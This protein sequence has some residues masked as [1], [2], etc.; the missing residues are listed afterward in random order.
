MSEPTKVLMT[1]WRCEHCRKSWANRRT[2]V[3]HAGR[4]WLDPGNRGCK[5]CVHFG[6]TYEGAETCDAGRQL[7]V[8]EDRFGHLR[9]TL[10]LACTSHE[11]RGS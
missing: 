9:P 2:A 3:D 5:T 7:P 1:R 6:R 8:A 4:C 10:A 11:P